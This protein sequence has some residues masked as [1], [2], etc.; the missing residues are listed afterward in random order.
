[1]TKEKGSGKRYKHRFPD[2]ITLATP[3]SLKTR[4]ARTQKELMEIHWAAL[5]LA[6]RP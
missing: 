2:P 6:N 1:M 4:G 3:E 5:S